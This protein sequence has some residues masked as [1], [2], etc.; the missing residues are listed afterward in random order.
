MFCPRSF[1]LEYYVCEL[2]KQRDS[3]AKMLI[4]IMLGPRISPLDLLESKKTKSLTIA[5]GPPQVKQFLTGL[6]ECGRHSFVKQRFLSV[7]FLYFSIRF[8]LYVYPFL[9]DRHRWRWKITPFIAQLCFEIQLMVQVVSFPERHLFFF[10]TI[11]FL[12]LR[13]TSNKTTEHSAF[14]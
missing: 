4:L 14:N 11:S 10:I 7:T 5:K 8:F 1:L 2:P 12:G 6:P 9:R 3:I 13:K